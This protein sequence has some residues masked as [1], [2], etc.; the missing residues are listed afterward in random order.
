[1]SSVS[2]VTN[3]LLLKRYEPRLQSQIE[4]EKKLLLN[5]EIDPICG[6]E[7]IPGID[8]ETEHKGKK[9]YFCN[10]YCRNEFEKNP[11]R[12]RA[13][14]AAYEIE[15]SA[16]ELHYD[17]FAKST[18]TSPVA[19]VFKKLNGSDIDH[20]RRIREYMTNLGMA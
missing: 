4:E 10:P 13:L 16:G 3:S 9:Y 17:S 14:R 15:N 5:V 11:D 7:V 20:A 1:M 6:M 18:S 19:T 2:V 8:I 12:S